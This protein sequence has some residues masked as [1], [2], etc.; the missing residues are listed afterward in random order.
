MCVEYFIYS[1]VLT[2]FYNC[3]TPENDGVKGS[4]KYV[5]FHFTGHIGHFEGVMKEEF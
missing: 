5:I 2:Y 1:V 4:C 3:Y